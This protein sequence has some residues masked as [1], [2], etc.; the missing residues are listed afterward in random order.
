[1][2]ELSNVSAVE[3]MDRL[4]KIREKQLNLRQEMAQ[5]LSGDV[6]DSERISAKSEELKFYGELM[7]KFFEEI[8][9]RSADEVHKCLSLCE[10]GLGNLRGQ[11]EKV[12]ASRLSGD[13]NPKRT[14]DIKTNI[15]A[16]KWIQSQLNDILKDKFATKESE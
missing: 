1:M 12:A 9:N 11:Q 10:H 8:S 7:E 13:E 5:I 4:L 14:N 6:F 3:F 2:E 16:L 15:S